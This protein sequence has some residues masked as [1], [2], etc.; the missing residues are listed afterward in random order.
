LNSESR[1]TVAHA[2]ASH[3][4]AFFEHEDFLVAQLSA[5]VADGLRLGD[6]TIVIA[7]PDHV[8]RLRDALRARGI[9]ATT[10]P[11][12]NLVTLDAAACVDAIVV[13]GVFLPQRLS[14]LLAPLW[15][16]SPRCR[17]FGEMASVL[18]E[19]NQLQCA[20][21]LE[22]AGS[23]L[24]HRRGIPV[25]CGYAAQQLAAHDH[26]HGRAAIVSVHDR[27]VSDEESP[28]TPSTDGNA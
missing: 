14:D 11:E 3:V 28:G 18:V 27:A 1:A 7:T 20:L 26:H 13:D 15:G 19:R 17:I 10:W 4:V 9:D 2:T 16:G 12:D 24:A 25:L 6:R 21:E 8:S 23:E 22:L 5:F